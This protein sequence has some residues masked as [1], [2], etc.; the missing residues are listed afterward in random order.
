[1]FARALRKFSLALALS[2]AMTAAASAEP[3]L[4]EVYET[5]RTGHLAE[6]R[7]MMREVLQNHPNSAKAHYVAAEIDARSGDVPAAAKE[8]VTAER[9]DPGLSFAK[10]EAV[11]A[12]RR[13]LA[14]P[15]GESRPVAL[16]SAAAGVP[17]GGI[18]LGA[19]LIGVVWWAIRRRDAVATT[20]GAS[21]A[22]PTPG[23]GGLPAGP[24]G[25]G[26]VAAPPAGG[27]L[28]GSLATGM[29]VGAGVVAGEELVRHV[30]EPG[31]HATVDSWSAPVGP[32]LA[33]NVDMGGTDFGVSDAGSWDS[34]GGDD[35]S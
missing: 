34:G 5:A 32:D 12:L 18:A 20:Q 4:H 6:A 27:G 29:A 16:R 15:R 8:L 9:L 7:Q 31:H 14:G 28:L 11:A 10:P 26:G 13:E 22:V 19:L 3:A 30:L 33:E 25:Y 21:F 2:L 35:W 17:W 23:A 1:M 24:M